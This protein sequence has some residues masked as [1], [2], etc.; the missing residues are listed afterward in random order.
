MDSLIGQ[1][2]T[3]PKGGGVIDDNYH[4]PIRWVF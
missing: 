2:L 3:N 4:N 1:D